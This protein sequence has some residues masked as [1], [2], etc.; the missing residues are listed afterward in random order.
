MRIKTFS[1]RAE[2]SARACA[3]ALGFSIPISVALDNVLLA[4]I[5]ICWLASGNYRYKITAIK[6]NPVSLAAL[7]LFGLLTLGLLYGTRNPGDGLRYWGKYLDILFVPIFAALFRDKQTRED[8]LKAFGG[9]VILS[10]IVSFFAQT[11]LL[12]HNPL[13]PQNY[14]GLPVGFKYSITHSLLVCLGGFT[15]MLF[16]RQTASRASRAVLIGLAVIAAYNVL[17]VV[18]S[19]TGYVVLA[20][21]MLYF[22]VTHFRWRGLVAA[23]ALGAIFFSAGYYGSD[24]FQQRVNTAVSE[25][26]DWQPD[27]PAETSVGMRMEFYRTSVNIVREHPLLGSGTGSFPAAYAATVTGKHMEETVNPHNEYLLIAIQIGLV[28][29]ACLFYLFYI[30]WRLAARLE[31][32]YRD[33]ARGLVLVFVIGCM[34]NSLLLDHTEGLLFAWASGLLFAGLPPSAKIAERAV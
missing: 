14:V 13:L 9:A 6:A 12:L 26:R 20:V 33:L 27:R 1:S 30:E 32:L 24:M 34:F 10:L 28:G 11:G 21:L 3:I 2:A 8:G 29:L 19:R 17:F 7:L 18:Y 15:F 23:A 5:L 25:L 4:L 31:P 22:F 16:A